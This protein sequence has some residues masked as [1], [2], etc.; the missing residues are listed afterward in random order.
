MSPSN[1]EPGFL[2]VALA[3]RAYG[4]LAY[5][6][7]GLPLGIATFAWV[8]TGLSLSFGLAFIG[9]G[10]LL[11][12]AYLL[13]SRAMAVGQG[14][15]AAYIA[16]TEAPAALLVPPSEGFWARL[17]ALLKDPASWGAQVYLLLRMP[18]GVLGF[19]LLISMLSLSIAA[20]F[21]GLF[22]WY[23]VESYGDGLVHL[24]S[25][26]GSMDWDLCFEPLVRGF[27]R[28]PGPARL[29][30]AAVGFLGFLATLHVS[31]G[32]TRMEAAIARALLRRRKG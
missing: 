32:L 14:R 29:T 7:A 4:A 28:H 30:T 24:Q 2:E 17:G 21:L 11:G 23:R 6:I 22:P 5:Q 1:A 12:L 15:L 16:A 9:I 20:L 3:P 27:I 25:R 31:L 18:M 13:A 10:L 19:G 8:A 26:W